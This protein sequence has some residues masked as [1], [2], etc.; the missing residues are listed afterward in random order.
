MHRLSSFFVRV[1]LLALI[2]QVICPVFFSVVPQAG[3]V[4]EHETK[5]TLH[6]D[7]RSILAPQ[8]IKEKDETETEER[9]TTSERVTLIDFSNL[10]FV[11]ETHHASKISPLAFPN[12]IDY[13]LPLF[14][15][16]RV[17]II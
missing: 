3:E 9:H 10:K 15:L 11:L 12:H 1:V 6:A 16:H 8:L 2:I 5:T 17:L 13:R 7:H 14:Q 4:V